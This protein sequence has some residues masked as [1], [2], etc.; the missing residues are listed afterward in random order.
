MAVSHG[1]QRLFVSLVRR[2]FP[3]YFSGRRVLE[4]GSLDVNGTVRGLF[5]DCAY[6]GIDVAPGPGVD[7]VAEGQ[8][9]AGASESFDTVISCE[10]MEHNPHWAA[11]FDNMI[12]MT[13]PGGLVLMTCATTGRP[14]HGT[15]A[16][17]PECS[18]LTLGWDYYGNLTG[19]DFRRG[20]QVAQLHGAFFTY[21]AAHDL[22]Y[23]GFKPPAPLSVWPALVGLA[24]FYPL[25]NAW[26]DGRSLLSA[27][28]FARRIRA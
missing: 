14:E 15:P 21:R 28:P 19:D 6:T 23:L 16:A 20:T 4:I 27:R 8:D 24:A 13:R 26:R 11:T 10:V 18:P 7:V 12:R 2:C 17:M 22:Y 3:S 1:A 9:Y 5:C 25:A